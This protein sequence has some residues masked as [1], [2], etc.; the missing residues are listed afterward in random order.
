MDS[1]PSG[2]DSRVYFLSLDT[3]EA[4]PIPHLPECRSEWHPAF[5]HDGKHLAYLC[6]RG[7]QKF[8]LYS[9][10]LS[11]ASASLVTVFYAWPDGMA[12]S[13]DDKKII[14]S[15]HLASSGELDE[16]SLAD[17]AMHK[18][19]F[20]ENNYGAPAIAPRG[21]RLAYSFVTSNSNIW[22]R[23]LHHPELPPTNLISSSREQ[24][25][26]QYSPDGTHIA[27][28]ST[29]TGFREIWMS[30]SDGTHLVQLT[31]FDHPQT[32]SARWSPDGQKIAFDSRTAGR[33]EIYVLDISERV[34]RKL[35][36]NLH[37]M[38][39]PSW[40]HDGKW[41]YFL[42]KG[43]AVYRCPSAGGDVQVLASKSQA[44]FPLESP[45]SQKIFFSTFVPD[46]MVYQVS[47]DHPREESA[48]PGMPVLADNSLW[49]VASEG[50]YFIPKNAPPSLH[51]YDFSTAKTRLVL[52][53]DKGLS[54]GLSV[55]PEGRWVIYAQTDQLNADIMLADHFH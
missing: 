25:S 24:A 12:W 29:R 20:G 43:Q 19:P 37:D 21:D 33:P 28:D 7:Q 52:T 48:I 10:A 46:S 54:D 45:D 49:A 22:R 44:S 15:K 27:F 14:L 18:L 36:C 3:L 16:I 38:S 39:V 30:E 1:A 51:Y 9:V 47:L 8:A 34:P 53:I 42:G 35:D 32:G 13:V 41:I 55:S 26:A 4:R 5:S 40:S 23:D 11:T 6:W 2:E 31:K 50:I 17:G